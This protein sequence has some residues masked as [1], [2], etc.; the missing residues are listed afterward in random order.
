MKD[1]EER[2]KNR[3]NILVDGLG[4]VAVVL[5]WRGLWDIIAEVMAPWTS[6]ALGLAAVGAI[7]YVR[8]DFI[9]RLF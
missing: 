2:N 8:R 9:E 5:I 3:R 1:T 4:V 7:A 6:L